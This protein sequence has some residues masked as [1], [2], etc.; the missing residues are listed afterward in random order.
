MAKIE[1]THA[2]RHQGVVAGNYKNLIVTQTPRGEG[3]VRGRW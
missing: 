1:A 3:K 2:P